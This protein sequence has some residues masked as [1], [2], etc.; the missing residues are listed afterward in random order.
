MLKRK[1]FVIQWRKFGLK[2]SCIFKVMNFWNFCPFSDFYLIFKLIFMNISLFKSRKKGFTYLQ[3]LTWRARPAGELTWHAGPPHGC[4]VAL[5][6]RGRAASGPHEA[7]VAHRAWTRGRR[8]RVS[9]RVH[10]G[11]RVGR[12]VAGE[13]DRWRA[14][15]LVGPS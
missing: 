13:V 5:R 7:H 11:T 15:G 2:R 1:K 9:T 14:H 6:P 8:P 3:V 12:H 10:V 4:D